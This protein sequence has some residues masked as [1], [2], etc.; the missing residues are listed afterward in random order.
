VFRAMQAAYVR[1]LQNPF[2]DPD[3]HSPAMGRGGKKITSQRFAADMQRIGET[4]MP[5]KTTL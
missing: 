5:G 2:Y 4:W 1:L 3:E